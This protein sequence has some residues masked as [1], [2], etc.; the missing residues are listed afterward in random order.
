MLKGRASRCRARLTCP[1]ASSLRIWLLET[2]FSTQRHLGIDLHFKTHLPAE[3]REHVHV[4][5]GFVAKV[6][7]VAFMDFA[8][9]QA[10]FQ[11]LFGELAAGSSVKGRA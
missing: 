6:K 7:V 2:G 11:D 1:S 8:R 10:S 4:A 9:M 3:F 5:S